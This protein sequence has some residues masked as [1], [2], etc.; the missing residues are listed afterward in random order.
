[1]SVNSRVSVTKHN[2]GLPV[3]PTCD[4]YV[5]AYACHELNMR[6]LKYFHEQFY[7]SHRKLDQD[8]LL[9]K[10]TQTSIVSRPYHFC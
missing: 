7:S 2:Y 10:Y 4:H 3:Y 6:D 1:M 5:G 9:L 8:T